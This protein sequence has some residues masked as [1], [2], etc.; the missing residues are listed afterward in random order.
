MKGKYHIIV[1]NN[2]LRY[3]F[4]IK[5]NITIIRGDSATGKTTLISMLQS[6]ASL[7]ESSGIDVIC[8]RPCRVLSGSDWQILLPNLHD[9]ILF[10]DEEN[11]F[12]K[13]QEF[14][15]AIKNSD[16]YYVIITREDLPNLPYS[17][18]EIYGIH[19]SGKYHDLKQTYNEMYQIYNVDDFKGRKKPEAVI[20]ED[21][22]AGYDFFK[23]V[24][25]D[26]G[27]SCK[28][29]HGKSNLCASMLKTDHTNVLAIADG[30][31]IG[32]EMNELSQHMKNIF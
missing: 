28:S 4:D 19:A 30:A 15:S 16:N 8:E 2:R 14:A 7:G 6:A 13:T 24:C 10:L 31:A 1:Q 23:K 32:P 20:V 9:Q 25:D 22:N 17:V 12:I 29:A 11:Q 21:S 5:R 3:E 18:N 27:I 26:V